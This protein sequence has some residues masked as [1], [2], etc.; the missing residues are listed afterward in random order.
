MQTNPDVSVIVPFLNAAR[1]LQEA[2][3][4]VFTQTYES[5]E[6]L[7]VDD[8]STDS[9]SKI[10]RDCAVTH[11]QRV[12]YLEH[13]GH[14]NRGTSSSRNLAIRHM[15]GRFVALLDSDDAWFPNKLQEQVALL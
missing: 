11:P 8:G 2:I 10:A 9:S 5:W 1:F 4:S 14:I 7:L 15:R 6:L 13:P 3:D 12:R